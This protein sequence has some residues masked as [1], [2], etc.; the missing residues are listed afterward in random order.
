MSHWK[1]NIHLNCQ[2]KM[3]CIIS[4]SI[5]TNNT[6]KRGSC[7]RDLFGRCYFSRYY[8]AVYITIVIHFSH[9]IFL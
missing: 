5:K 4:I 2:D 3:R 1:Q 7:N 8:T 6:A 9:N